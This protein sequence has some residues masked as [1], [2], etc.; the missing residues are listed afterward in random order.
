M[1]HQ[2]EHKF[3]DLFRLFLFHHFYSSIDYSSQF[4]F[5]NSFHCRHRFP[6]FRVFRPQFSPLA[7]DSKL[8]M[9]FKWI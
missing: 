5:Q 4:F 7:V 1:M 9:T 3:I 8:T 2:F 6:L